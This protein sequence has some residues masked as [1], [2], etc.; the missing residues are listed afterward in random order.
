M[1]KRGPVR[2]ESAMNAEWSSDEPWNDAM[3][4]SHPSRRALAASAFAVLMAGLFASRSADAGQEIFTGT[5]PGVAAGGFDV[6]AYFETRRPERGS[7]AFSHVW[8]GAEWRF[9]S[10]ARRDAFA[11]A[12][13]RFAPAYGGHCSWAASQGYKAS[14][15]PRQWR[16]VNG[17]LFLNYNA[18]VHQR[19]QKDIAG[20]VRAAD[21]QW[22]RI[23]GN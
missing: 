3:I 1:G 10:A 21:D 4:K 12:P 20:F 9:A 15:D 18:E 13:E 16:I 14:G 22:P 11:A 6:V 17:R 8:K 5:I 2:N 23:A 19:W 7:P